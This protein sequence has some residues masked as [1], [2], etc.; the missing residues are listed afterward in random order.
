[1]TAGKAGRRGTGD[2]GEEDA[3]KTISRLERSA[4]GEETQRERD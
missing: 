3:A 2:L 1:M 4:P